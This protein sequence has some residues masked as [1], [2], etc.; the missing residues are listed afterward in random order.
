MRILTVLIS[1]IFSQAALSADWEKIEGI[2]AITPESYIDPSENEKKDSHYRI[3][4]KGQSAQDLYLAMKAKPVID[5]CTGGMAKNVSDM[6][7]LYYKATNSYECHFSINI[8]KQKYR[9]WGCMLNT[10]NKANH[11]EVKTFASLSLRT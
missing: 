10:D 3:Q 2:Y 11:A 4:L 7:C 6:Q 1:L 8:S 5:E 9:V